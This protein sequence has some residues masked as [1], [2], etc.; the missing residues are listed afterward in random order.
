[1][2]K[3]DCFAVDSVPSWDVS[4]LGALL[5]FPKAQDIF[6]LLPISPLIFSRSPHTLLLLGGLRNFK[7]LF[8]IDF[9]WLQLCS[10]MWPSF[11]PQVK[12]IHLLPKETLGAQTNP[13]RVQQLHWQSSWCLQSRAQCL[14]LHECHL[15]ISTFLMKCLSLGCSQTWPRARAR[16]TAHLM[17]KKHFSPNPEKSPT[18]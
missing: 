11:D 17:P 10:P 15:N 8:Q 2:L 6:V 13:K 14:W 12:F 1:M 18:I 7:R 5:F 16:I 3:A 4:H 9:K